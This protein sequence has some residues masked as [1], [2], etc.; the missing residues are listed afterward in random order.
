MSSSFISTLTIAGQQTTIY[1]G[2]LILVAGVIGGLFNII[3]F[4][5]LRT[6]RENSS[7]F[8]LAFMSIINVCQLASALPSRIVTSIFDIDWTDTSL[9]YCKFRIYILQLCSLTSLTSLCLATID[10]YFATC[11]HP[12]Y[13]QWSN[14]KIAHRLSMLNLIIWIFH[15]IPYLIYYDY[16]ISSST[17]KHVCTLTNNFFQQYVNYIILLT[18]GRILPICIT[19]LFGLLAYCNIQTLS[20]RNLPLI[21]RELDKQITKMVLVQVLITFLS[22]SP[23]VIVYFLSIISSITRDTN[24]AAQLHLASTISSTVYFIHFASPFYI[25]FCAS[26]R[27]RRQLKYVLFDFYFHRYQQQNRAV[28]QIAPMNSI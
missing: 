5:S 6:F 17:E 9:F 3:V 11:S 20:H 1:L 19:V 14:I 8:Y 15:N 16:V 28:N 7:G 4:F 13:Q 27:F 18:L 2:S 26:S 21:R 24:I 12:R 25:Y 10:Q 23:Y 22:I